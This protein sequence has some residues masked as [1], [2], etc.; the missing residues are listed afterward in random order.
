M[1]KLHQKLAS[2][3]GAA[4]RWCGV[5]ASATVLPTPWT[6]V[7]EA[8]RSGWSASRGCDWRSSAPGS[9]GRGARGRGVEETRGP[10][11]VLACVASAGLYMAATVR[12]G[13][14]RRSSPARSAEERRGS[15]CFTESSG[16]RAQTRFV[17]AAGGAAGG[18]RDGGLARRRDGADG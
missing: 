18:R 10:F 14:F 13:S 11:T 6:S 16:Q 4:N 12:R 17:V 7:F 8:L 3:S 2:S 9:T 5:G 15:W 1:S